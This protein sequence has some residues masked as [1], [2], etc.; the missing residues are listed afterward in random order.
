MFVHKVR[1]RIAIPPRSWRGA[2]AARS[3][4]LIARRLSPATA[5]QEDTWHRRER[6]Q[7]ARDRLLIERACDAALR[8]R[9]HHGTP[10]HAYAAVIAMAQP[11]KQPRTFAR[12]SDAA[13][14]GW[15]W[16]DR[17][18]AARQLCAR[19]QTPYAAADCTWAQHLAALKSAQRPQAAAG[20]VPPAPAQPQGAPAAGGGKG[21]GKGAGG[22]GGQGKGGKKG[23][24]R[25]AAASPGPASAP[26]PPPLAQPTS[27]AEAL[28]VRA[29]L[30]QYLPQAS[31]VMPNSLQAT[32][33][34]AAP[35]PPVQPGGE[36]QQTKKELDAATR[37]LRKVESKSPGGPA[38]CGRSQG[39]ARPRSLRARACCFP[40][41]ASH[42]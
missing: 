39:L 35:P 2:L 22:K 13:C 20:A 12:C 38:R 24:G 15:L 34:V 19:C 33:L 7:R 11:P 31:W 14:S 27:T 36:L 23:G 32:E 9:A 29:N 41:G 30:D 21:G 17:F 28:A 40:Q 1:G 37:A 26:P 8:L 18:R 5:P 10:A 16:H 25:A 6:R 4:S 3:P 42:R